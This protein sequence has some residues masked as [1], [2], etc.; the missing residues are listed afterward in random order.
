MPT[1]S[2]DPL[3]P[4]WFRCDLCGKDVAPLYPAEP[5]DLVNLTA[6]Q[7]LELDPEAEEAIEV[8]ERGCPAVAAATPAGLFPER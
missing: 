1:Y 8:H 3:Y 2:V 7:V 6:A 5:L 4:H